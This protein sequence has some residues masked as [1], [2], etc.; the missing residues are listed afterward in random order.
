[1]V[2]RARADLPQEEPVTKQ[3][4]A[5]LRGQGGVSH[6]MGARD[7]R[8]RRSTQALGSGDVFGRGFARDE[9][10]RYEM[11]LG[12]GLV[13]DDRGRPSV[14]LH[15]PLA[16]LPGS[17]LGGTLVHDPE[18]FSVDPRK[19]I[20]ARPLVEQIRR[21][22]ARAKRA[23]DALEPSVGPEFPPLER[24]PDGMA[25]YL[26]TA[27]QWFWWDAA[28]SVWWGEDLLQVQGYS[29]AEVSDEFLR[30]A[31]GLVYAA[32]V[33]VTAPW[34]CRA[35]AMSGYATI[36]DPVTFHVTEDGSDVGGA[37]MG[38]SATGDDAT[39][40]MASDEIAT[41]ALLG[42]RVEGATFLGSTCHAMALLRRVG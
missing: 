34:K 33:G 6:A 28:R 19:G 13:F 35:V 15:F 21:S 40:D 38:L 16:N 23:V 30:L 17:P 10:G 12:A 29:P 5:G 4:R 39:P 24:R 8:Y 25:H 9:T 18:H 20:T 32:D 7:P 41:G 22:E 26:T 11:D 14:N 3:K 42:L 37:S 2:T 36:V 31:E 27:H 1:M